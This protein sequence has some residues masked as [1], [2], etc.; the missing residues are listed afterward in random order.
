MVKLNA[1]RVPAETVWKT[2]ERKPGLQGE[3]KAEGARAAGAGIMDTRQLLR[4]RHSLNQMARSPGKTG[5]ETGC[6]WPL[7][8]PCPHL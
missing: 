3:D 8:G 6:G 1:G 4:E 5:R 2:A 7:W